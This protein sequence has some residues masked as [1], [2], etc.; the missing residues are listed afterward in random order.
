MD[1]EKS[2]LLVD[3]AI[4]VITLFWSEDTKRKEISGD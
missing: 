1:Q 4:C 3:C 2:S